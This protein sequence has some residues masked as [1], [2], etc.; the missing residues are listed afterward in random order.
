MIR[1]TI[2]KI[3]EE[4]FIKFIVM[5]VTIKILKSFITIIIIISFFPLKIIEPILITISEVPFIIVS[6][7]V[8][9]HVCTI[10]PILLI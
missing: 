5:I 9:W 7:F 4:S 3:I 2:I 1:T 10:L 8:I 6:I